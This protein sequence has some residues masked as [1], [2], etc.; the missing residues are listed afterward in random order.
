MTAATKAS[1]ATA[2]L[3]PRSV[4]KPWCDGRAGARGDGAWTPQGQGG[5][6]KSGDTEERP[7]KGQCEAK[8]LWQKDG[9][10]DAG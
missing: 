5:S 6:G 9:K 8:R 7:E 4:T 10:K 3:S 2:P 1:A